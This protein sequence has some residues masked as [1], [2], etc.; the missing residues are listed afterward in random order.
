M[1]YLIG[2]VKDFWGNALLGKKVLVTSALAP[3][4]GA[5]PLTLSG[6]FLRLDKFEY[7]YYLV[8]E[9]TSGTISIN[10]DHIFSM[11]ESK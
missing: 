4:L 5:P 2:T 7:R 3:A 10:I 1:A 8:L 9:Q 6:V 11:E